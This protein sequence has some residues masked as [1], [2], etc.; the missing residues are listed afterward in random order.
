MF[1]CK[2]NFEDILD[3]IINIASILSK[4]NLIILIIFFSF[5]KLV[6]LFHK[7]KKSNL[8]GT[9]YW[10]N[11]KIE[12]MIKYQEFSRNTVINYLPKKRMIL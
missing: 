11:P 2:I 7:I 8:K 6:I 1:S 12:E 5:I 3:N 9:S 4:T 10:N